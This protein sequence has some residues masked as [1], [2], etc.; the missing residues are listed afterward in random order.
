MGLRPKPP[1]CVCGG[2]CAPR[3]SRRGAPCAPCAGWAGASV[4]RGVAGPEPPA[5]VC[6][7]PHSPAPL[8]PRR[9]VRALRR[10]GRALQSGGALP[11]IP[12]VRLRGP[13]VRALRRLGRRFSQPR[14]RLLPPRR[15]VRALRRLGRRFSQAGRCPKPPACVCGG[16]CAPRHS[17]RGAPC[18]PCAGW[19]GASVR[20]GVAPSPRRPFA[21]APAPRATPAEARRAR[22]APAGPALQ[23]GGALPRAPGVRLRGPLRPAPLPPRRAVRALRRLGRRFSQA[24]RCPKPPACACGGP[25][26]PRHS[27]RG[28]PC[29]PCAGWAGAS[30][31]R[32][33]APSPRRALAGVS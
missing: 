19:A 32:G 15:A 33:V 24:G 7:G 21:G 20:R 27:R 12:G 3:H 25:C 22:L 18:A 6:G 30:V 8:L 11:R 1:A 29:A 13:A 26:A 10:L 14:A 2:P 4:R 5:C 28:A 16:P 9:A 23:S 17:R 31:R